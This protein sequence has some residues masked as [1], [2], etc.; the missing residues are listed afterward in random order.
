M[1]RQMPQPTT[2]RCV[3]PAPM[4]RRMP[5]PTTPRRV[6]PVPF[7]AQVLMLGQGGRTVYMGPPAP[8]VLYFQR[9]LNFDVPHNENP[10][11]VL[12]DIIAGRVPRS[13][14]PLFR[15]PDLVGA[16][17]V[18]NKFIPTLSALLLLLLHWLFQ[19]HKF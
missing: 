2:P 1:A 17:R 6:E 18:K 12:M 15:L 19:T 11:D 5:Q 4:T 9:A 3:E 14:D 16:R 7:C 13:G 10:A 8:A